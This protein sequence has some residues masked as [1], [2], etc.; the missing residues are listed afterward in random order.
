[1]TDFIH[2]PKNKPEKET[3]PAY[4]PPQSEKERA[5]RVYFY[6][7][8]LFSAAFLL[9]LWSFFANNRSNELLRDELRNNTNVLQGSLKENAAQEKQIDA[10]EAHIA[11]L[12]ERLEESQGKQLDALAALTA[13]D[14]LREIERAAAA[15]ET[16]SAKEMIREFEENDLR[17][18]LWAQAL[19]TFD[20]SDAPSPLESYEALVSEL[21]PNGIN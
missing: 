7:I 11:E 9:I 20:G 8:V 21:F 17:E 4:T 19:H 14:W 10:L 16:E 2:E 1:M 15:G 5:K 13:L 18:S 6:S 3:K 12:E